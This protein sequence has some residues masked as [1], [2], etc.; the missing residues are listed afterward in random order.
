MYVWC[1]DTCHTLRLHLFLFV[2][3]TFSLVKHHVCG[4]LRALGYCVK[5]TNSNF[6]GVC[7]QA[8]DMGY[9]ASLMGRGKIDVGWIQLYSCICYFIPNEKVK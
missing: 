9:R 3:L 8:V 6:V 7:K 1:E 4:E 5:T 2:I